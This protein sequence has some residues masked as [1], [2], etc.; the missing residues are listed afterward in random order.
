MKS[1]QSIR[2]ILTRSGPIDSELDV[3]FL[4]SL[5][6]QFEMHRESFHI[7]KISLPSDWNKRRVFQAVIACNSRVRTSPDLQLLVEGVVVDCSKNTKS[8]R[9]D[10]V[11]GCRG[12]V[13]EW[14]TTES[15]FRERPKTPSKT[16]KRSSQHSQRS[17]VPI[18]RI[19][20]EGTLV[21]DRNKGF[22]KLT[23]QR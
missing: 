20:Q 22:D 6:K 19:K 12:P 4:K 18:K 17:P 5:K 7:D 21:L 15:T 13:F 8:L 23:W 3:E 14:V 2:L 1:I 11:F 9:F 10:Y 16:N